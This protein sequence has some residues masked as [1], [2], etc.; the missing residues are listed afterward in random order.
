M[1]HKPPQSERRIASWGFE[2]I[3]DAVGGELRWIPE[4]ATSPRGVST[5]TRSIEAGEL[6]VA[7]RGENFDGHEF[8][9]DAR[10]T[11]ASGA[12]V[13]QGY[14]S[15]A[16]HE[17]FPII[18]VADTR[19]ALG[20][21][22]REVWREAR[23]QGLHTVDVTGS[24]GKTTTKEMLRAI[25]SS[26]G[27]TFATL[28]NFNNEIGLPLTLCA[29]PEE[30]RHLIVEIGANAPGEISHLVAFAP[31][32]QRIITSIGLAHTEGFGSLDG[33]RAAKSEILES[34][35]SDTVGIV[36]YEEVEHLAVGEFPGEIRTFGTEP[37]ADLRLVDYRNVESG[38][39]E[40]EAVYESADEVEMP[41]RFSVRLGL[42]GKH[43]GLN[44]AAS[45]LTLEA[46]GVEVRPE[47]LEPT[48]TNLELPGGR[49]REIRHGELAFVDDAY[50]ANPSSVRASFEAF[51]QIEPP[52]TMDS[53][54]S[55]RRIA[56]VGEMHELGEEAARLHGEVA[57]DV[58]SS[59]QLEAF[60]AVGE[61]SREMVEQAGRAAEH[62]IELAAHAEPDD[63]A[64]WLIERAPAFVWMKASRANELE[65]VIQ[66]VKD[67][68]ADD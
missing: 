10:R 42:P 43:N 55:L 15:G 40:F 45:L 14:S 25:W 19:R 35:D 67:A 66:R 33:V 59:S 8:V 26:R 20:N 6:F 32:E 7:L 1:V 16:L 63:V 65:R 68:E 13:E 3:A 17:S 50:N 53:D 54:E 4:N 60:V 29:I 46:E 24:N 31:G 11:E 52:A 49:W 39:G 34:A 58:A 48:L 41:D 61:F 22:G 44:L 12:I 2:K 57:R 23:A 37:G 64:S 5:D 47:A 30:A 28:G 38:R 9:E 36:P 27:E 18:Y 56:V 51:L 21:L 62:D